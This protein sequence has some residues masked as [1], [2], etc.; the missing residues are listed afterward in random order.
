MSFTGKQK[1]TDKSS[2]FYQHV[3]A[4]TDN[5]TYSNTCYALICFAIFDKHFIFKIALR[6]TKLKLDCDTILRAQFILGS[7]SKPQWQTTFVEQESSCAR[8]L[9]KFDCRLLKNNNEERLNS[10]CFEADR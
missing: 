4:E 6:K 3:K 2:S 5:R 10:V 8:V 7:F 1:I 9:D